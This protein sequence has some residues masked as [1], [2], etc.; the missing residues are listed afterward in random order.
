MRGVAQDERRAGPLEG[1]SGVT[2]HHPLHGERAGLEI[3]P[4]V[5]VGS[6]DGDDQ[7]AAACRIAEQS[8][9]LMEEPS[10]ERSALNS[11]RQ[12]VLV[13]CRIDREVGLGVR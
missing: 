9:V 5:A 13:E 12:Q 4:L 3:V 6:G 10:H 1:R 7:R 2:D 8:L 11:A